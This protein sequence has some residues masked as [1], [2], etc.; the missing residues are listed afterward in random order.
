MTSP[1]YVIVTPV[2]NEADTLPCT[3]AAVRAQSVRPAEWI[4]VDDGSSDGTAELLAEA[5]RETPW[6]RVVHRQDRGARRA[7]S[8]VMEAFHD[9]Y[10]QLETT[11]WEFLVK[12]DGDLDFAPAYFERCLARFGRN[13]RLGIGGG[14]VCL[15]GTEARAE[16]ND[17]PF[18]VRGPTKI[19][20]RACWE[21]IGGLIRTPGWDTFDLVK[22]NLTGWCTATFPELALYHLRPSGGAYGTW[23]NWTKNGF[24]NYVVGYHPLFMAAKCARRVFQPP[25]GVAALGLAAGFVGGYLRGRPQVD[26]PAAIA[27]LRRQQLN[28][29]RG[30]P[31]LWALPAV[32]VPARQTS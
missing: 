25:F 5:A 27:Y 14:L 23:S 10:A 4:I 22:A 2:R 8:G 21:Q 32:R 6:I 17:P 26:E 3:L 20:R 24:A 19:Y 13:P 29:L 9:G 18:H 28:R 1:S 16:F 7:G 15:P 31:S 12:L 11:D 30:R